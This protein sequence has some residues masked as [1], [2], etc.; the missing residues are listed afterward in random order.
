M[1]KKYIK[2][3]THGLTPNS[4]NYIIIELSGI[5]PRE[6]LE[7]VVK[8]FKLGLLLLGVDGPEL[9]SQKLAE[10]LLKELRKENVS[11]SIQGNFLWIPFG[12]MPKLSEKG[13]LASKGDALLLM[14]N[15]P[16]QLLSFS[17]LPEPSN[18][19][20]I[21]SKDAELLDNLLEPDSIYVHDDFS[22]CFIVTKNK[23]I[24]NLILRNV[25]SFEKLAT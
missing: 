23:E 8:K 1:F 20:R 25:E 13:W 24:F 10:D 15:Q 21:D 2:F 14:G 5:D 17:Y 19:D 6:F 16:T 4:L 12:G 9:L 11:A 3:L 7:A 18:D 22:N